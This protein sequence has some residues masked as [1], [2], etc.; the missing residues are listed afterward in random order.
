M[1]NYNANEGALVDVLVPIIPRNFL[2]HFKVALYSPFL[3]S[4]PLSGPV[5][6]EGARYYT[7]MF[8]LSV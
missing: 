4:V 6:E 2:D 1:V 7:I 8:S 5:Y 3:A